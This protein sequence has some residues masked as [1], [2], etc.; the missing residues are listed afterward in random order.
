MEAEDAQYFGF[1]VGERTGLPI[2]CQAVFAIVKGIAAN[3]KNLAVSL[4]DMW[5][6]QKN[7]YAQ[8]KFF[9]V[10][11][12]G[13]VVICTESEPRKAIFGQLAGGEKK[14]GDVLVGLADPRR[15]LKTIC[16]GHHHIEDAD[17]EG[18]PPKGL[19]G[20]LA[21]VAEGD[22]IAAQP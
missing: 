12:L 18:F 1:F 3:A 22:L 7:F 10:E 13:D 8:G 19:E 21:V 9:D 20:L 11:R 14:Q 17:I 5:P 6:A 2:E 15:H 4:F 16:L